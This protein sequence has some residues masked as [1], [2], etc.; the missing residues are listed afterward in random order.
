[1]KSNEMYLAIQSGRRHIMSPQVAQTLSKGWL[2]SY[3]KM[4]PKVAQVIKRV[5]TKV[6][7]EGIQ[8]FVLEFL[9]LL[10]KRHLTSESFQHE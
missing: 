7:K 9:K 6:R 2:K 10:I 1:M 8:D 5:R 4:I 3:T